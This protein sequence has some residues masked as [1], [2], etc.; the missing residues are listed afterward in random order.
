MEQV[1]D[2]LS[3]GLGWK[4][5]CRYPEEFAHPDALD[6]WRIMAAILYTTGFQPQAIS[7]LFHRHPSLFARTVQDPGNLKALFEW[8]QHL[9]LDEGSVVRIINKHPLVL[10][11]SV[12]G[13]LKPRLA[14]LEELGVPRAAAVAAIRRVPEILGIESAVLQEKVDYLM[15]Q[16]LSRGEVA[17]V[18]AGQPSV[19]CSRVDEKLDPVVRALRDDLGCTGELLRRMIATSGLLTRSPSTIR[20]RAQ[21]WTE[22]GLAPELLRAA[23]RRFPRLL[24]YPIEDAKYLR[25]V[26]FLTEEVELPVTALAAFPQFVSYSLAKRL[27]PRCAAAKAL[28]GRPP[29][30]SEFALKEEAF[31]QALALSSEEYEAFLK[32]WK[33]SDAAKKWLDSPD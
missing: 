10:Q 18:V 4:V 22:L 9:G 3:P 23:L 16:G 8:F 13:K 15:E 30:V 19:L 20:S 2:Q 29:T 33:E 12:D 6:L 28:R 26:E 24:L 1:L 14:Y 21:L 31:L 17:K 32:E 11:T 7:S 27:A 25:K 5:F